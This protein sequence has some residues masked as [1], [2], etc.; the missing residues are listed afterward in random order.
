MLGLLL[1]LLQFKLIKLTESRHVKGEVGSKAELSI[2]KIIFNPEVY[3]FWDWVKLI[4]QLLIS[5]FLNDALSNL[6][7]ELTSKF[8]VVVW[9]VNE[10][11]IFNTSIN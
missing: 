5:S 1:N 6:V 4:F 9:T 11:I 2:T 10:L 8:G 7:D 3:N